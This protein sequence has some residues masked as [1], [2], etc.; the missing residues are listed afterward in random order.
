MP[1]SSQ[2]TVGVTITFTFIQVGLNGQPILDP[3]GNPIPTDIDGNGASD[4]AFKE[5]WFNDALAYSTD[6]AAGRIDIE[7]AAL[8]E[9]GHGVELGHFGKIIGD[10]KTGKLHG[11]PAGG[12]ER[13]H[14]AA[15]ER[16]PLG[17]DNGA[18]CGNYASW[19]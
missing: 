1:A 6:G 18:L 5:V 3:N 13:G 2:F 11:K 8:H 9:H 10:P 16:S 14:S 17:T 12:D 7:S 19:K 4:T 15:P